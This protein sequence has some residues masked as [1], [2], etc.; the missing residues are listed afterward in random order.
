MDKCHHFEF[1]SHLFTGM[2]AWGGGGMC[3]SLIGA[4]CVVS[5]CAYVLFVCFWR[6]LDEDM[7]G[8]RAHWV[9]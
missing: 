7:P 2:G 6:V 1:P 8:Q 5:V 4:M 3:L 9:R